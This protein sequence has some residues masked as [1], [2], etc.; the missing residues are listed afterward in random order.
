MA[1]APGDIS[2]DGNN[3]AAPSITGETKAVYRIQ[4]VMGGFYVTNTGDNAPALSITTSDG[5]QTPVEPED[6]VEPEEPKD[7]VDTDGLLAA[8]T[9][10]DSD[11]TDL[12]IEDVSGNGNDAAL[13]GVG[14]K[15]ANGMLTLPGGAHAVTTS[16]SSPAFVELPGDMFVGQDTLTI[17]IWLKNQTGSGNYAAMSFGTKTANAGGGSGSMPLNYWLLN[18]ANPSGYFK[19]VWTDSNNSGAPYNTET[20]TSTTKTGSDWAMY[21]TVITPDRIVGYLNGVEV[22]GGN[23]AKSKTTTDFGE[24]LAAYIGRSGYADIFYKGGVYGVKVYN[25]AMDQNEIWNEYYSDMPSE[26]DADAIVNKAIS[27]VKDSIDLGDVANVTE[28]LVLPAAGENGASIA[29]TSSNTDVI[30]LDGTVTRDTQNDVDVT[31]TATITVGNKT[32]EVVYN[33]TVKAGSA[34]NLFKEKVAA[35]SLGTSVVKEDIG[36]PNTVGDNTTI[37][38]TSDN[39]AIAIS[40]KDGAIT[41]VVTRPS[42]DAD[43]AKVVL[44]ATAVYDDGTATYTETKEFTVIVLADGSAQLMAY[45]NSSESASLGNS[46]HLAYSLDGENY[47]ALNSNTGICFANNAGGSKNSSPNGLKNLHIFRKADGTYGLLATN[48]NTQKYIYVFDSENLVTFTNERKLAVDAAVAGEFKVEQIEEGY[49]IYWT[50]GSKQYSAV[51]ADLKTVISQGEDSYTPDVYTAAGKK[52]EGA[53]I[54]NII[55]ITKAEYQYI[56]NKLGI[57]K[58][59]GMKEVSVTAKAGDDLTKVLPAKVTAEYNDGSTT[60]M[61]VVWDAAD[62]A[63]VDL[64]K[65][66]TYTVSGTVQQTQYANPFI[67]QRADPCILKGND[68]YYYFTASYPMCGNDDGYDKVVLRRAETINGLADAEEITI[69]DCDDSNSEYRYIWAPEIRLVND[70]YYVFYTSSN[71]RSNVWGIRPHVLKCN[72]ADDIMNPESWEAMGTMQAVSGD[73]QAFNGFSLD[74]TVFE[75]DDRWYVAWAQTVGFSS[76]LLAEIDPDEPW[77]C[78]SKSIVISAPEYSWERQVENVNEGPSIIKNNGKIYMAFSASGTGPEYCIG[79]LSIDETDD[80][81]DE[82]N[83]EKQPYPVLTSS[84]VPGEYGPGH[85]SFTFDEEGNDIFVYHARGEECY[86]NQCDW[87]NQG[88]LYDPC[89]DARLK[90]VHWAVDGTPILKMSYEEELASEFKMVTATITVPA[91]D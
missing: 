54:G 26:L 52:P 3:A 13:K 38:W 17:T 76:I 73:S 12:I 15:I 70:E 53:V 47:E 69:W 5:T 87:A 74:M 35:L 79:L 42:Q 85:N 82:D 7:P 91:E 62:I 77:K 55:D 61:N 49:K 72:D 29:W 30:A 11:V 81:L 37:T 27:A 40:E 58:N 9:F 57:V 22:D 51:T 31:L 44:T 19:S 71:E 80:M 1:V 28:N 32:E 89:R 67:E 59:T 18:P 16:A 14:A 6:P 68:G 8:Y 46:L 34:E 39:A 56:M 2:A 50:D 63:K 83:W 66:G 78:I 36:L 48:V 21:T 75:N 20:A 64:T 88:S 10:A 45:T 84:D 24:N 65:S 4:A 86:N 33:V 41:G 90:R 60:D 43:N 23:N 25:K